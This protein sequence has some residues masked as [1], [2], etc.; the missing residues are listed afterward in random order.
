LPALKAQPEPIPDV[1]LAGQAGRNIIPAIT[2]PRY[3]VYG[4]FSSSITTS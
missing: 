2:I 4:Y 3:N 1:E